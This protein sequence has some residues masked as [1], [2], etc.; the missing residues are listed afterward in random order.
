[1]IT[2]FDFQ[3]ENINQI[4]KA[5]KKHD[6][7][8]YQLSTGG[9][10]TIIF[11]ALAKLWNDKFNK[12][13]LILCHRIELVD[14]TI[15]TLNK[16]GVTCEAVTSKVKKLNHSSQCYVAMIETANNRL[17]KDPYFFKEVGL[18][19]ADECHILIF[20]KVF[21]YFKDAKI[22]GCTATP[23]V[24]KRV[25]FYKCKYCKTKHDK[26]VECCDEIVDEWSKPFTLSSIY[27]D[28]ICGPNI[29]DL[30]KMER[31]VKEISFVESY[32][33]SDKLKTDADGEFTAESMDTQYGSDDAV[34]N[35]LLNYE[36]L[37]LGKKTLIFNNSAK[38][39]ALL[40]I[41]FKEAGYN[42][43]MYDSINESE[44]TRHEIVDWFKS[45][46]DAVLL[47]V[48]VFTTGLDVQDIQAII[49]NRA[50][51]SLSLFIQ[52]AGRGGR[53]TDLIY[54][55]SF[56]LVDGGGNIDRHQEWSDPT[57]DWKRIFFGLEAKE[58]MKKEDAFDING[59][60]NCGALYPKSLQACP[61]CG[62]E[63]IPKP[64]PPKS[65]SENIL[66][67]IR[68]IPPPNAE[69]IYKYTIS[70]NENINFA[71]KILISQIVDLF[72]FYRVPKQ[73]YQSNKLDGRL[74]KRIKT[75]IQKCYFS[76][77][78]KPDIK[79]DNNR[80]INSL[81]ERTIIKLDKFYFL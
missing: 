28:I 31:L 9:G 73:Q 11:S 21:E 2:L 40:F 47:N 46:H 15:A 29:E 41:K 13:V 24:M 80:T 62:H 44:Y 75:L 71:F 57:R 63:I 77:L 10:K 8:C 5:F 36:K 4:W 58:K 59:C 12:R 49:I 66:L 7:I 60:E 74:L 42:V 33:D 68:K 6:K 54:K 67:P 43:R 81:I 69:K 50:I 17:K 70:R 30:I 72:K 26:Q 22:L 53:V 56:I 39:N 48:A 19:I 1:M 65:L 32:I 35:V 20:D 16:M 45:N 52:I 34:F 79:A 3:K 76:L 37:C 51:G 64:K 27:D 55:D 38:I 61:E 78:S 18:L 14:Q 23:V 25:Y